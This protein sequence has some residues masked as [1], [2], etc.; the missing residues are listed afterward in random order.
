MGNICNL[1][2]ENGQ[3]SSI[4]MS[5]NQK[6]TLQQIEDSLQNLTGNVEPIQNEFLPIPEIQKSDLFT[7]KETIRYSL[8]IAPNIAVIKYWGKLEK[9]KNIPLNSSVSIT[10][11]KNDVYSFTDIMLVP[12]N[13]NVYSPTKNLKEIYL[14]STKTQFKIDFTLNNKKCEFRKP[15]ILAVDYF[16][17]KKHPIQYFNQTTQSHK[18]IEWEEY[19]NWTQVIR[20]IN[21]F[22]TSAGMASS[23][24]GFCS[25]AQVLSVIFHY[26]GNYKALNLEKMDIDKFIEDKI[27][28]V[29]DKKNDIDN[30]DFESITKIFEILSLIRNISGSA[31]RSC[32]SGL[33]TTQGSELF[34]TKKSLKNLTENIRGDNE[35]FAIGKIHTHQNKVVLSE[36]DD[37]FFKDNLTRFFGINEKG[38]KLVYKKD[39][40]EEIFTTKNGDNSRDLVLAQ[41]ELGD[42][43]INL[44]DKTVQTAYLDSN[45]IAIPYIFPFLKS[46][47]GALPSNEKND[48]IPEENFKKMT[49]QRSQEFQND[50]FIMIFIFDTSLKITQKVYHFL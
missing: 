8:K 17:S 40:E 23:A 13:S 45:C 36:I 27:V 20:S 7:S 21:N 1:S 24:S 19:K 26:F 16:F 3:D 14:P 37:K 38:D 49:L 18:K 32:F 33:V 9:F 11:D 4:N 30:H 42:G 5:Y 35:D 22:P 2:K 48:I 29:I 39:E 10:L 44:S 6:K 28:Y 41:Q 50:L 15:H 31:V 46:K 34:L 25:F 43:K 12:E 47:N